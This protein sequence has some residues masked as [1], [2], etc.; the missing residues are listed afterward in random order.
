MGSY[1]T[2]TEVCNWDIEMN[3]REKVREFKKRFV[4]IPL[5]MGPE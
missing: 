3:G 1:G 4:F 2:S 5:E